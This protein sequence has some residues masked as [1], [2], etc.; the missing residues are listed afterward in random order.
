MR[1]SASVARVLRPRGSPRLA[2]FCAAVRPCCDPPASG[3]LGRATSGGYSRDHLLA[4]GSTAVKTL[5]HGDLEHAVA[6]PR[7]DFSCV[8]AGGGA[9]ASGGVSQS[10]ARSGREF[11]PARRRSRRAPVIVNTSPSA[12]TSTVVGS[13][14]GRSVTTV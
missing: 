1:V 14:P 7:T 4:C 6:E 9:V 10:A 3:S 13:T 8:A 2:A 12:V 11:P 5:R